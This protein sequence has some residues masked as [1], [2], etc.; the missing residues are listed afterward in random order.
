[1]KRRLLFTVD[2]DRDVNMQVDGLDAAGSIDRGQGTSP[3]FSSSE[4]GLELLLEMLDD[5]G[6]RA[7]F[8]VEGRTSEM[9]DCSGVKGHCV[10]FH[11]YDHEDL[12]RVRDV[13][14]VMERGYQAVSDNVSR[15]VCFRAPYMTADDR[16][17]SEL[18]ALG[19][20]H[21]SSVYADPRVQ[22]YDVSGIVEHPVAKGKDGNGR[23]MAAYLWPMHE[24]RRPPEDYIWFAKTQC[25]GDLVIAT[26]T[27]HMVESRDAGLMDDKRIEENLR[28]VREVLTGIADEGFTP[29]VITGG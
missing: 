18:R 9:F 26:H 3:R 22:P 25:D 11:G 28:D 13:H 19:I 12:T 16:V 24:S 20:G 8:F 27:W 29:S 21:D 7:T 14:G 17:M 15:P 1:M 2:L 5:I 6:M 10:G 23:T 4:R